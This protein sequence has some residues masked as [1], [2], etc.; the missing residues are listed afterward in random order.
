MLKIQ[1]TNIP[2][3][4]VTARDIPIQQSLHQVILRKYRKWIKLWILDPEKASQIFE[5]LKILTIFQP[6]PFHILGNVLSHKNSILW[7]HCSQEM[8]S[9]RQR[10]PLRIK[11]LFRQP[12]PSPPVKY[13][14]YYPSMRPCMPTYPVRGV[15]YDTTWASC[16]T[17]K[18]RS[19]C[20]NWFC[21][22]II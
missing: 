3:S 6:Q 12:T 11:N 5:F 19:T 4:I 9:V 14:W 8:Q 13:T 17:Y 2:N 10:N 1:E 16:L 15:R 18:F 7:E 21:I 20:S 22:K